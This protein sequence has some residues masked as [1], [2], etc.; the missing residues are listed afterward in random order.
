MNAQETKQAMIEIASTYRNDCV[1]QVQSLD[2]TAKN[3]RRAWIM[4]KQLAENCIGFLNLTFPNDF[5]VREKRVFGE[6]LHYF[7]EY[8][9]DY[10][11]LEQD[12]K[13]CFLVYAFAVTMVRH[14][15]LDGRMREPKT[16]AAGAFE[17]TI[18]IGVL[19]K[20]INDW[21]SYWN[22]QGCFC[23]EVSL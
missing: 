21:T 15:L 2:K 13:E 19:R 1:R 22:M 20:I 14:A 10:E 3:E 5:A 18:V 7:D 16:D 8:K 12:E 4:Q 23:C 11:R 17:N 6:A 9:T